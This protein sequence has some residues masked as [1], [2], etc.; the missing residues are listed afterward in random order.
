VKPERGGLK[1]EEV[2]FLCLL[3]FSFLFG[4]LLYLEM[5]PDREE[6]AAALIASAISKG[7]LPYK[8]YYTESQPFIFY[9]YK[10]AFSFSGESFRSVRAFTAAYA[11]LAVFLAFMLSRI[12]FGKLAAALSAFFY[13]LFLNNASTGGFSSSPAVFTHIFMML[14]LLFLLDREKGYE[15]AGFFISGF[16]ISAAMLVDTAASA[17][18]AAGLIYIMKRPEIKKIRAL[19]VSWYAAGLASAAA[20]AAVWMIYNGLAPHYME[21][22]AGSFKGMFLPGEFLRTAAGLIMAALSCPALAVAAAFGAARIVTGE[23]DG[24]EFAVTLS[25]LLLLAVMLLQGEAQKRFALTLPFL[26]VAAGYYTAMAFFSAGRMA[27]AKAAAGL[28]MLYLAL[29]MAALEAFSS[30]YRQGFTGMPGSRSSYDASQ[31]AAYI[32][33]NKNE[34]SRLLA[35]PDEPSIYFLS[36]IRPQGRH[37]SGR[38]IRTKEQ[39]SAFMAGF[40]S[41]PPDFLVVEAA[42]AGDFGDA[43]REYYSPYAGI[44]DLMLYHKKVGK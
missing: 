27:G 11:C 23:R 24:R 43:L 10:S 17:A 15:K 21:A 32:R 22:A 31:I 42:R 12:L 8:D 39:R 18:L 2:L 16:F 1:K 37:I 13:A 40:F 35:W 5:P 25:G 36:G 3:A 30:T 28:L 4:R 9:L 7:E 34:S 44:G 14:S 20:L 41:S 6:G 26:S 38:G 33:A 19:A 29:N